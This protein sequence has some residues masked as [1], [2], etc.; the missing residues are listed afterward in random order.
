M[1]GVQWFDLEDEED[2]DRDA[3]NLLMKKYARLWRLIFMKYA[4]HGFKIK[5]LQERNSF[6]GLKQQQE[7]ISLAEVTKMMRDYNIYP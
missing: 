2:R 1:Y 3:F 4:N 5:T 6:E 7:T